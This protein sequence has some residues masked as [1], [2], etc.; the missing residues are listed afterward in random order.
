MLLLIQKSM[1]LSFTMGRVILKIKS[2]INR[3]TCPEGFRSIPYQERLVAR[4][5]KQLGNKSKR[6]EDG[7]E[8]I[9]YADGKKTVF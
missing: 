5:F 3:Q 4:K 1:T 9:E 6:T 8:V 2:E 7:A